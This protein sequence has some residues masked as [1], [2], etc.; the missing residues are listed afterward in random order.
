MSDVTKSNNAVY[1][2]VAI[3][4]EAFKTASEGQT[5]K[6][7]VAQNIFLKSMPDGSIRILD[8]VSIAGPH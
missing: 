2:Y 3:P 4:V 6:L 8:N 7:T 5:Q 1:T